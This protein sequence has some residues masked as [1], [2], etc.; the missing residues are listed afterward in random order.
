VTLHRPGSGP[1]G[2]GCCTCAA[3]GNHGTRG[4]P[5]CTAAAVNAA[6]D[7]DR[8]PRPRP[9]GPPA[10]PQRRLAGSSLGRPGQ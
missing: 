2:Q 3:A 4:R 6:S 10:Q 8:V 1:Q 5:S 7:A 9:W